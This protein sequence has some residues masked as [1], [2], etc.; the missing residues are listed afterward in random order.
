MRNSNCYLHLV[1]VLH[2]HSSWWFYYSIM[3][4]SYSMTH[5]VIIVQKSDSMAALAGPSLALWARPPP[6]RPL[7]MFSSPRVPRP[8]ALKPPRRRGEG[9]EGNVGNWAETGEVINPLNG[10]D[11]VGTRWGPG[12]D[13]EP[14]LA[15]LYICLYTTLECLDFG[16]SMGWLDMPSFWPWHTWHTWHTCFCDFWVFETF[17]LLMKDSQ[18]NC[19]EDSCCVSNRADFWLVMFMFQLLSH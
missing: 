15:S 9:S 17:Q 8:A 16:C 19:C 4:P 18:S 2:F 1:H 10:P 7:R 12:G 6:L 11:P 5:R 13:L 14:S 3:I